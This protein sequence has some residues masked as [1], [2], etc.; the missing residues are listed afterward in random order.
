MAKK[1]LAT[2]LIYCVLFSVAFIIIYPLFFEGND[3][4]PILEPVGIGGE[5]GREKVRGGGGMERINK[6]IVH[7]PNAVEQRQVLGLYDDSQSSRRVESPPDFIDERKYVF[8]NITYLSYIIPGG[9][10]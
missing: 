9:S 3:I 1:T 6:A 5:G 7:Q 2:L 8:T 10:I 4:T